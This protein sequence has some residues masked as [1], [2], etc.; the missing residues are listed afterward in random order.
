MD[1][2]KILQCI[3][4]LL[5]WLF[6]GNIA[7]S[8]TLEGYAKQCSTS[9]VP[10]HNRTLVID[11][12]YLEMM[13]DEY[14]SWS[15]ISKKYAIQSETV[16]TSR[17]DANYKANVIKL[18]AAVDKFV[19]WSNQKKRFPL[20]FNVSS[21]ELNSERLKLIGQPKK[22]FMQ[23]YKLSKDVDELEINSVEGFIYILITF[24]NNR[25]FSAQYIA[26]YYG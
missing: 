5:A 14:F 8:Q 19:F 6:S 21:D 1:N 12:E 26:R 7:L 15:K 3:T 9:E 17:H 20:C 25:V 22:G 18:G 2:L 11:D 13:F 10:N 23:K 4:V 24:K 16:V